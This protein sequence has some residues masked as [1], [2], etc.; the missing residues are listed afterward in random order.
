MAAGGTAAPG[1]WVAVLGLV[2]GR[3][4]QF[5]DVATVGDDRAPVAG[6]VA[7]GGSLRRWTRRWFLAARGTLPLWAGV[8]LRI[9][10]RRFQISEG[11]SSRV[12]LGKSPFL[13]RYT[14]IWFY[15]F[16]GA[17]GCCARQ[18]VA[19]LDAALVPRSA[20]NATSLDWCG[21]W[22]WMESSMDVVLGAWSRA[23]CRR[24]VD[25][26]RFEEVLIGFRVWGG[27]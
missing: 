7:V 22:G 1:G 18:F 15:G 21:V 24:A 8:A 20:R 6:G 17:R 2:G 23:F 4:W 12:G 16:E 27:R 3:I 5:L 14:Q 26:R 10:N 13:V 19:P 25:F 9:S 11:G